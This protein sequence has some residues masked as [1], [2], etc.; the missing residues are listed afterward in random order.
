MAR[1]KTPLP[2]RACEQCGTMFT[3]KS[4][5][6]RFHSRQCQ[7]EAGRGLDPAISKRR[8]ETGLGWP[9]VT[10]PT[11]QVH[12]TVPKAPRKR[13]N[14]LPKTA[15]VL[16]DP[17]IGFL[18]DYDG[19]LHPTHDPRALDLALQLA[20]HLRPDETI[21]LGDFLDLAPFG[22]FRTGPQ[23]VFTTQPSINYGHRQLSLHQALALHQLLHEG[24]HELRI[25]RA[26]TD[27]LAAALGL[28]RAQVEGSD[29]YPVLSVPA[30]LR[31]DELGV[32]WVDGY[33]DG[34]HWINDN[35]VTIHGVKVNGSKQ[36]VDQVLDG[37]RV[38]VIQGH[39][40]SIQHAMRT[41]N[42]K[43][44]PKFNGAW[45]PGTLGRIDGRVPDGRL[46]KSKTGL[47]AR[48]WRN[49]QQ[50]VIVVRYEDT[51]EHRFHVEQVPIFEGWA[52]FDG[53][54][55]VSNK[56]VDDVE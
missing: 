30:L 27:N 26:A 6:N 38:S 11:E 41:R 19:A 28:K 8:V 52:Y 46:G 34:T 24:N 17:Q 48:S 18:R 10:G 16:P 22:G 37:E 23:H 43:T 39:V 2:E 32:E 47:P 21:W 53:R 25:V 40:H 51:G 50:G 29:E 42:A 15:L 12:V 20:E 1:T 9:A 55:F 36:A 33:P 44:K 56:G 5:V 35:L 49:W 31:L 45:S 54:E 3:P 4:A 7:T 14:V 13:D